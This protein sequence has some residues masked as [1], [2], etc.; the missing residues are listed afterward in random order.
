M[1]VSFQRTLHTIWYRGI[2]ITSLQPSPHIYIRVVQWLLKLPQC[3]HV[4]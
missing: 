4:F 3:L 1:I 2:S